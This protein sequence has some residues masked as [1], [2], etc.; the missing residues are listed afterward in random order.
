[1]FLGVIFYLGILLNLSLLEL[2]AATENT[3]RLIALIFVVLVVFLGILLSFRHARQQYLFYRT[4]IKFGQKSITY[5]EITNT[6]PKRNLL[7]YIFGTCAIDV[8]F[9]FVFKHVPL[10]LN[11]GNYLQQ[12]VIYA[13]N[14][15]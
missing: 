7:D 13:K 12:L 6:V 3:V 5:Q 4:T 15:K 10:S 8:G 2:N 11:L 1:M 14:Q 9:G